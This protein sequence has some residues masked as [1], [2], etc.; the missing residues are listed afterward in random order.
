ML[1]LDYDFY[2]IGRQLLR[3]LPITIID[4]WVKGH[5]TGNNRET[6]HDLN[7]IAD[8][9]A[10]AFQKQSNEAYIPRQRPISDPFHE[11]TLIYDSSVVTSKLPQLIY[12][13]LFGDKLRETIMKNTK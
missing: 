10:T 2:H 8:S 13:Q 6:K 5:Y 9:L 1:V 12:Q 4:V 11:A 3:Q 7:D